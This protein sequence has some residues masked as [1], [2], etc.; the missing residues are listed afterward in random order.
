MTTETLCEAV[1]RLQGTC[2]CFFW[3][4]C[5]D[6]EAIQNAQLTKCEFFQWFQNRHSHGFKTYVKA[7]LKAS[8]QHSKH[9]K[10]KKGQ[11]ASPTPPPDPTPNPHTHTHGYIAIARCNAMDSGP[12]WT[13]F[14]KLQAHNRSISK[15]FIVNIWALPVASE[16]LYDTAQWFQDRGGHCPSNFKNNI[17][18][19][20]V[21]TRQTAHS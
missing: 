13:L 14:L 7:V 18:V 3:S 20:Q 12:M 16:R 6:G 4:F 10:W 1:Q 11:G 9:F 21:N 8:K 17:E 15:W 5:D 19:Y 2:D